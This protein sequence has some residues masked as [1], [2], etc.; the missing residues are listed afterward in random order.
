MSIHPLLGCVVDE[1]GDIVSG[2]VGENIV[3]TVVKAVDV[4]PRAIRPPCS[5][6]G[7]GLTLIAVVV[8]SPT[9]RNGDSVGKSE[10]ESS[11]SRIGVIVEVVAVIHGMI[12]P[13][14]FAGVNSLCRS[15]Q[16]N[17]MEQIQTWG[18]SSNTPLPRGGIRC[19]RASR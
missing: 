6:F 8:L 3:C 11:A 7:C 13:K 12:V 16:Q 18:S 17:D 2:Q 15:F 1:L 4:N 5:T 14:W 10:S 9:N 19:Q